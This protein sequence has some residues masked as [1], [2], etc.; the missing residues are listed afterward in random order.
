MYIAFILGH[1]RS[2]DVTANILWLCDTC[3]TLHV[4]HLR[5]YVVL[6]WKLVYPLLG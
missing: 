6:L 5:T 3:R 1:K 2:S 4:L